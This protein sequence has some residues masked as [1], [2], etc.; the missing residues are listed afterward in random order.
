MDILIVDDHPIVQKGLKLLLEAEPGWRVAGQAADGAAATRLVGE[1]RPSIAIVDLNLPDSTGL[2]VTASIKRLS[3]ET[4]VIILSMHINDFY[5]KAALR[6]GADAYVS[7]DV[8]ENEIVNAVKA[9]TSGRTYPEHFGMNRQDEPAGSKEKSATVAA[10]VLSVRESQVLQLLAN[11]GQ[12]KD[13][14][15]QL[16]ISVRTAEKHRGN[17]MR[18]LSLKS[19]AELIHYAVHSNIINFPKQSTLR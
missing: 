6:N 3:P 13:V 4:R 16:N 9:V 11:G 19:H 15:Q 8:A 12:N 5:I 1:L 2:E 14:A 17:I 18:K 7:K 10:G